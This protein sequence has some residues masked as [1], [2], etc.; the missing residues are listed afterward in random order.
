[1]KVRL[2]VLSV[3]ALILL[4]GCSCSDKSV[5]FPVS[6]DYVI[7]RSDFEDQAPIASAVTFRNLLTKAGLSLSLTTDFL[8][9]AKGDIAPEQEILFGHTDRPETLEAEAE[10]DITPDRYTYRIRIAGQKL[11]VLAG[12]DNAYTAAA[13]FLAACYDPETS[14]FLLPGE[15][16]TGR[17]EPPLASLTVGG[18]PIGDFTIVADDISAW[19]LAEKAADFADAIE[20]VTGVRLPV[21]SDEAEEAEHEIHIASPATQRALPFDTDQPFCGVAGGKLYLY[22]PVQKELEAMLENIVESCLGKDSPAEITDSLPPAAEIIRTPVK[23]SVMPGE[24]SLEKAFEEASVL[25]AKAATSKT[26]TE[27]ILELAD[28]VYTVTDTIRFSLS[29]NSWA[30]I[31]VRALDGSSPVITGAHALDASAFMKVE[32]TDYYAAQ[33]EKDASGSYPVF[34]DFWD[35]GR[36]IAVCSGE[37]DTT[38]T[39]FDNAK[40]RTDP[41]NYKGIYVTR[42]SV[43][44]LGE[45]AWPTEFTIHVEWECAILHAVGVDYTDTKTVDGTELVRLQITEKELASFVP[46]SHS[47]LSISGREYYFSNHR[48]LMKPDSWMY[49]SK[50]G[51]LFYQPAEGAPKSPAFSSLGVL[52]SL[53]SCSGVRFEG[54]TFTGIGYSQTAI[55]GYMSNQTNSDKRYGNMAC[56]AVLLDGC[57][58]VSFDGCTFTALGGNG[59][60][61]IGFLNGFTAKNNRFDDISMSALS[62]GNKLKG[63]YEAGAEQYRIVIENNTLR[64]IGMEYPTAPAIYIGHADGLKILHNSIRETAYSAISV[65]W[66]YPTD[67]TDA[68]DFSDKFN[69]RRAEIAYNRIEDFM[70]KLRDGAAI[71]ATGANAVHDDSRLLNTIHDN[72]AE[73]EMYKD[74]SKRG[75]YLDGSSSNWEI[76]DCV[77]LGTRL[78]IF[79]QFHVST[80]Y[81]YHNTITGIYTDYAVDPGNHAPGRHTILGDI[82]TV[83]E[84]REALFVRY[85]KAEEIFEASGAK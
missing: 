27:I 50:T 46:A 63:A 57:S 78:P 47:I 5:S 24:G 37:I 42:E 22:S 40:N 62:I 45:I 58:D 70:L 3:L 44:A 19:K 52:I 80:Q 41:A 81:T 66:G 36:H 82:F 74:T 85:P 1:M 31:T 39:N 51:E 32:G 38:R 8:N 16:H 76:R 59:I 55:D 71:Y 77:I 21:V 10:T 30:H 14:S 53:R 84:G 25:A 64:N 6:S 15:E 26:H 18:V 61:T 60:Q 35:D 72:Y 75:Y 48:S 11:V 65:G 69:V 43:E 73:R 13:E 7:T 9:P 83:S 79:S 54:I 56:A 4:V 33:L 68:M 28:G 67:G 17:W 23:L 29:G 12:S 49:N 34:H 2:C 20:K